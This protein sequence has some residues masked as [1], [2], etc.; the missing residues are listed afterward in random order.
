[1]STDDRPAFLK[2]GS[3][4]IPQGF[5]VYPKE[6]QKFN[7]S[8]FQLFFHTFRQI[9]LG[10]MLEI[11]NYVR[12]KG[13]K[14]RQLIVLQPLFE[15]SGSTISMNPHFDCQGGCAS[16]FFVST[17][18]TLRTN[19]EKHYE[20]PLMLIYTLNLKSVNGEYFFLIII[21]SLLN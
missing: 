14:Q 21:K 12:Q 18:T 5:R 2:L 3:V 6:Q 11:T 8:N 10:K 7:S 1:M 19:F 20:R 17:G 13:L 15:D 9:S 4:T 16:L